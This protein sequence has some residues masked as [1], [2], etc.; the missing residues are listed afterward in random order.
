MKK[1][2]TCFVV[3]FVLPLK[4]SGFDGQVVE[5]VSCTKFLGFRIECKLS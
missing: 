3:L 5:A 4:L 2:G 1:K